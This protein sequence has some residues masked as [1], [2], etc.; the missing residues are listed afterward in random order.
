MGFLDHCISI[1][2]EVKLRVNGGAQIN[3][4]IDFLNVSPCLWLA[5]HKLDCLVGYSQSSLLFLTQMVG[6]EPNGQLIDSSVKC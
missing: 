1:G 3:N 4:F 6:A 2:F 5:C